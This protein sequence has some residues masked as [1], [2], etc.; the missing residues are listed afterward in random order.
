MGTV[1]WTVGGSRYE[2]SEFDQ[3]GYDGTEN[4]SEQTIATWGVS[5]IDVELIQGPNR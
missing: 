2:R 3:L 1:P 4:E 5:T